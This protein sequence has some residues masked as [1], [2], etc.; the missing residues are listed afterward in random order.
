MIRLLLYLGG[1]PT[2]YWVG[3][4]TAQACTLC[5]W[6][7]KE[8]RLSVVA[9]KYDLHSDETIGTQVF[10]T[11]EIIV[12]L[13]YCHKG[14]PPQAP[15]SQETEITN[16]MISG[17]RCLIQNHPNPF[18]PETDISYNL[19]EDCMVSLVVY[20][21]LGQ[22]IRV[23]VNE[24]QNAGLKTVH[25]DGK[26]DCGNDLASGVYFCRFQAGNHDECKKMV[27]MR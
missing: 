23:L 4:F 14:S 5:L 27:L 24:P 19:P 2:V 11:G 1:E 18:N 9:Y 3:P 20:N 15:E 6:P 25:W 10:T 8:Y 16:N 7:N 26:D 21:M 13:D 22:R 17:D 12:C